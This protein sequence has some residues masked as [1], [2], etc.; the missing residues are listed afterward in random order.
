MKRALLIAV[1][2]LVAAAGVIAANLVLLDAGTSGSEPVG[3]L[4]PRAAMPRPHLQP[5][6]I[7]RQPVA[8]DHEDD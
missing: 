3:N 4:T 2:L 6:A 8:I 5:K 7:V 1:V